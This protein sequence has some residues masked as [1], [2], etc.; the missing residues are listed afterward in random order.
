VR[1]I[2]KA[3]PGLATALA[4]AGAAAA[5]DWRTDPTHTESDGIAVSADGARVISASMGHPGDEL[6]V[7]DLGT[8][9]G[10]LLKH[11][12]K[13]IVLSDPAVSPDGTRLAFVVG[14]PGR[15]RASEIWITDIDGG[16]PVRLRE[17]GRAYRRPAFSP[18]GR[19]LAYFRDVDAPPAGDP[20]EPLNGPNARAYALFER[21]LDSG[22]EARLA[23]RR[24]RIPCGL[25]YRPQDDGFYYC[26]LNPLLDAGLTA[27]G[28]FEGDPDSLESM[29]YERRTGF[30]HVFF[31]RRGE[32]IPLWPVPYAP[33]G[34]WSPSL[35]GVDMAGRP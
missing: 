12:D 23:E 19:R 29:A 4:I 16:H 30:A 20:R 25:A 15:T 18:D 5:Q 1:R 34:A 21:D 2:G 6:R 9:A 10:Y 31:F 14:R 7:F 8:G 28:L 24:F 11:P 17:L 13:R 33:A 26:A 3:A 27:D 22:T 35:I 32:P